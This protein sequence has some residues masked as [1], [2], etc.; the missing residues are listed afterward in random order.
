MSSKRNSFWHFV[1][2]FWEAYGCTDMFDEWHRTGGFHADL[3][4]RL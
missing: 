2:S 1:Q 4:W 3:K